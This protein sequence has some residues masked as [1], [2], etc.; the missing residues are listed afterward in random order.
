MTDP[1]ADIMSA[2]SLGQSLSKN[3][4]SNSRSQG[5]RLA[6]E[7]ALLDAGQ[8]AQ[9][10]SPGRD[11][12]MPGESGL[13]PRAP[14]AQFESGLNSLLPLQEGS[15]ARSQAAAHALNQTSLRP[16]A[17]MPG[18]PLAQ[19]QQ[20]GA[21]ARLT[22]P[23]A[24]RAASLPAAARTALPYPAQAAR[25]QVEPRSVRL[26]LSQDGFQVVVRDA[27]MNEAA[28]RKLVERV[29]ASVGQFGPRVN[30]IVVNGET[31]WEIE[32]LAGAELVDESNESVLEI[33]L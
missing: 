22:A 27:G 30:R 28:V 11:M 24:P 7:R 14:L 25:T 4:H 16:A 3:M 2:I 15:F 6:W 12:P 8:W 31:A 26:L 32:A 5:S 33:S 21:A 19:P 10:G 18:T 13:P 9:G 29:Q 17:Q 23:L 1:F 20:P